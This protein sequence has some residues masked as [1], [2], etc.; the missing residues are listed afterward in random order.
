MK[1]RGIV[2]DKDGTLL[3]FN[4]TWL[5]VYRYAAREFAEGDVVLEEL[6]L[7]QHGFEPERNRFIGGSLLAAGNNRQ[8]AIAWASQINKPDQVEH[9]GSQTREYAKFRRA[10]TPI[11]GVPGEIENQASP[12][13][14]L[15]VALRAICGAMSVRENVPTPK[16]H[17]IRC[18]HRDGM[19]LSARQA[20]V[21]R[22]N[23]GLASR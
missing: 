20:G 14:Q 2:F 11:A 16:L 17:L 4:R 15:A 18:A 21:A 22:L 1:Y 5:P 10:I 6:L 23:W 9:I 8:I 19:H 3:D 13:R 12:G 7:T